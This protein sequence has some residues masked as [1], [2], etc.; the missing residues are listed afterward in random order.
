MAY[1]AIYYRTT[2]LANFKQKRQNEKVIRIEI[3]ASGNKSFEPNVSCSI[4]W[5][6]W[7][8]AFGARLCRCIIRKC[9][10]NFGFPNKVVL[11]ILRLPSKHTLPSF[12]TQLNHWNYGS[13]WW[14]SWN[15]SCQGVYPTQSRPKWEKTTYCPFG[16]SEYPPQATTQQCY[17]AYTSPSSDYLTQFILTINWRTI[18]VQ[19]LLFTN[20]RP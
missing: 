14:I 16:V 18:T 12:P 5:M 11:L 19:T 7:W 20:S 4:K 8:C 2:N 13:G 15:A 9:P 10:R 1:N 6:L 17:W 3:V